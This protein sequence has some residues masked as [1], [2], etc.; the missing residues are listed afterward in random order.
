[1]H[2]YFVAVIILAFV[3]M[4]K[5]SISIRVC[6]LYNDVIC[7]YQQV[8]SFHDSDGPEEDILSGDETLVCDSSGSVS[9]S[10][11][12]GNLDDL[13]DDAM[14]TLINE[15]VDDCKDSS[16]RRAFTVTSH[17]PVVGDEA[18][19]SQGK[20]SN[21]EDDRN[22]ALD[23]L[24][25]SDRDKFSDTG[26]MNDQD[27]IPD[28]AGVRG[29]QSASVLYPHDCKKLVQVCRGIKVVQDFDST[30]NCFQ[31]GS[32]REE[33]HCIHEDIF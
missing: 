20:L 29:P 25:D 15:S 14:D 23:D 30:M 19:D 33:A 3:R 22:L 11:C 13:S 31:V 16:A 21:N 26:Y 17:A 28:H 18:L 4:M 10:V 24:H 32:L 2:I 9:Q 7:E 1:M 27:I 8:Q 12:G 5:V 6:C